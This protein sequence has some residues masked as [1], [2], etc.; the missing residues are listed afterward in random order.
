M[1]LQRLL[2]AKGEGFYV[3]IGAH[4]PRR[5]SNTCHYYL[6]G[7][8]GINVDADE[9]AVAALAHERPRDINLHLGVGL[10][11]GAFEFIHYDEPALNT[12]DE[13]MAEH[14]ARDFPQYRVSHTSMVA[15]KPLRT[16]LDHHLEPGQVIDFL[17]VDVEGKDLEVLRSND[18]D[19]F[20]PR[21]VVAECQGAMLASVN[22]HETVHFMGSQGYVGRAMTLNSV[23]FQDG[24]ELG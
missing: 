9:R 1:I 23:V 16:I 8:R 6:R 19:R 20:R 17:S 2:G 13:D 12:F 21:F 24:S 3:D 7:W 10:E 4:H 14:R 11:E 15:V 18:W 22:E 5:F